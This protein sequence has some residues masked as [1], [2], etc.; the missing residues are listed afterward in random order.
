M[1]KDLWESL[2]EAENHM[3]KQKLT[4]SLGLKSDVFD[5]LNNTG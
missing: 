3:Y 1:D 4:E 5:T 2:R